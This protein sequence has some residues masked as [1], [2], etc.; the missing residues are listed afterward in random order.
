M[1]KT[2]NNNND[3]NM[4]KSTTN[5]PRQ[6]HPV[7][8]ID[9]SEHIHYNIA[10][11]AGIYLLKVNNRNTRTKCEICSKLTMKIPGIFTINFEHISH[12]VL[13]FI[14]LTLNNK[15]FWHTHYSHHLAFF[16]L[17]SNSF[18]A[19]SP[20]PKSC[21]ILPMNGTRKPFRQKMTKARLHLWMQIGKLPKKERFKLPK[22]FS[23]K[24]K[25]SHECT[26]GLELYQKE[27][28]K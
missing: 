28:A 2:N 1:F 18:L 19:L 26:L 16:Q 22:L 10:N 6:T 5:S 9:T 4:L 3:Y 8:L 20:L 24:Q 7:V 23:S 15:D 11:P 25:H 17:L 13:V 12:L 14:L 27:T 21:Y